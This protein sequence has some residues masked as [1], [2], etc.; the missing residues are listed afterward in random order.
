MVKGLEGAGSNVVLGDEIE[1]MLTIVA[2]VP[3][4]WGPRNS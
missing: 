2:A 3:Y 4:N 1:I